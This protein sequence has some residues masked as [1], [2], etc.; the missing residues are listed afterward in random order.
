MAS[1]T[2]AICT[3]LGQRVLQVRQDT[4]IQIAFEVRSSSFSPSCAKRMIW[5]GRMSMYFAMGQPA[6]HLPHW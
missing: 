6:E 2:S 3:P 5:L 1:I 4:H